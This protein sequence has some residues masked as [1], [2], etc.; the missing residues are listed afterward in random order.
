MFFLLPLSVAVCNVTINSEIG[1]R[2]FRKEFHSGAEICINISVFNYFIIYGEMNDDVK[3]L[4]YRSVLHT[5][6]LSLYSYESASTLGTFSHIPVPF[7]SQTIIL[8]SGGNI[9]FSY[10]SLAGLCKT[11][12]FLT[13]VQNGAVLF[14]KD[15]NPPNDLSINDDKCVIF[16]SNGIQKFIVDMIIDQNHNK[17]LIYYNYFNFTAISGNLKQIMTLNSTVYPTIFRYMSD[18]TISSDYFSIE[19]H[20]QGFSP[21][22]DSQEFYDPKTGFKCP[23][24]P[25]I[26]IKDW[27]DWPSFFMYGGITIVI[28][29]FSTAIFYFISMCMCPSF[30]IYTPINDSLTKGSKD[31]DSMSHQQMT[32]VSRETSQPF[33]FL[34]ESEPLDSPRMRSNGN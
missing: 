20:S 25:H 26:S 28:V 17:L 7:A 34:S 27:I 24:P 11:G 3:V 2:Q 22:R 13:N 12:I 14:Q 16:T 29:L 15:L 18:D 6:E 21:Y 32:F 4:T 8:P 23:S 33:H 19:I 1:L 10:G 31:S 30:V 5:S 9:S